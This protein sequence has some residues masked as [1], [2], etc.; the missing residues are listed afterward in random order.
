MAR[1]KNPHEGSAFDDF[2]KEEKIYDAVNTGALKRVLAWKI[3]QAMKKQ[4]ITKSAMAERMKTSRPAV[5]RLLDPDNKSVT[6]A[7]L[8]RA[9][10]VLGKDL[11]LDIVDR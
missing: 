3:E 8:A 5:D 1:K 2:L 10:A 11:Q 4:R 9:A 6:L 7:T